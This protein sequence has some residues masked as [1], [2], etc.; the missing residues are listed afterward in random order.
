MTLALAQPTIGDLLR[1]W[2]QRRRFS[3]LALACE[4]EISQ[5]HLSFIESGRAMP[6]RDMVLRLCDY[7]DIPLRDRN[8]L[9]LAA[10]FAPN[11][12]ERKFDDPSLSAVRAAV[13][14]VL[15]GHEPYPAL[16]LDLRWNL[17]TAN[18]A[19]LAIMADLP[20]D[21]LVPPINV[22]R[23][24]LH[25]R[26]L[27]PAIVNLGEWRAHI[28]ERLRRQYQTTADPAI[29][30]L[31]Q[32]IGPP[33][34]HAAS[35]PD[36]VVVPLQL[37]RGDQVLSFFSTTTVFGTPLDVTVSELILEAFYPADPATGAAMRALAAG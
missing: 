23:L 24:S 15:T 25:P 33:E 20:P 17:L 36:L 13:E 9:L 11:F 19:A 6:S 37:R 1:T 27:A 2:R 4:A 32:E 31:L 18:R 21:L 14:A 30:A 16:A 35:P 26:G 10:G 34:S 3:Q 7:L 22:V 5:R 29:L 8:A 28:R 12:A